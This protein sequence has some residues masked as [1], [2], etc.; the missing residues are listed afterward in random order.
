MPSL[1]GA[2]LTAWG[3]GGIIGPQIVAYMKDH[4]A[5]KAGLYAFVVGGGLLVVGLIISFT[6][7]QQKQIKF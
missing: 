4:Y 3:V 1:Y 6:Y 2:L 5:D 7:K